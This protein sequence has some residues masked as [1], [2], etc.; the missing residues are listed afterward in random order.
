MTDDDNQLI[1]QRRAKLSELRE[2]GNAFPNTFRPTHLA[3][4]LHLEYDGRDKA[5][6]AEEAVSVRCE[7]IHPAFLPSGNL[8]RRNL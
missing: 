8:G 2:A 1:Q 5:E 3:A 7:W 4:N 6:L